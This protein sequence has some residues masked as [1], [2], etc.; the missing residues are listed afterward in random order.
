MPKPETQQQRRDDVT[1]SLISRIC[2][3][4]R[5]G[6]ENGRTPKMCKK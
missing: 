6:K 5:A 1:A 3:S 4:V 2:W